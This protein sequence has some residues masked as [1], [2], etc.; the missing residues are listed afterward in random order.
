MRRALAPLAAL[1]LL[2]PT[3]SCGARAVADDADDVDPTAPARPDG[4]VGVVPGEDLQA[5]LDAAADGAALCLAPGRYPGPVHVRHAV[6]L[7]GPH[8]AVIASTGLGTTVHL[9]AARARLLGVTV[10]GSGGRYDKLDGAV[11]VAADDVVIEG[12]TIEGAVYGLLVEKA[13]RVRIHG[14]HVRG[15]TDPSIGLRGD[16]VRLWETYDSEVSGNL[17]EDGRDMV[18]WYSRGNRIAD[19]RIVRGR[20]GT[21]FMYSDGS[22]VVGNRYLDVT[23]GVFVMYSQDLT[24]RGNVVANAAGAAGIAFGLKDS[25]NVTIADNLL[26]HDQVGVYF[27]ATP[28]GVG[29]RATVRGNQLRLCRRAIVF[30]GVSA[31]TDVTGN[32]FIGNE[33][34]VEVEGGDDALGLRWD[35]NYFDDYAGYD[36]DDDGAGDVPYELRAIAGGLVGHHPDLEFFTGT[37]ALT[38]ADAASRLDPLFQPKPILVDP[39]PRMA[40]TATAAGRKE[41]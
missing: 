13:H 15:G 6:T 39:R 41:P 11:R 10:D 25:G 14:N 21:H 23:V 7:W 20:Y 31:A 37:P 30:H 34:Q 9:V 16:T 29:Q 33:A 3:A 1:V 8:D 38:M 26:V 24:L 12:V 4:C 35:G 27:D 22:V 32:D 2:A 36:L 18:V 28:Q 17:I 5:R 19:N 40:P